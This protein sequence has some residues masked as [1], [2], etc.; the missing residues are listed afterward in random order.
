MVD[1]MFK[2]LQKI[3]VYIVIFACACIIGFVFSR[4]VFSAETLSLENFGT[5]STTGTFTSVPK[6]LLGFTRFRGMIVTDG[7]SAPSANIGQSLVDGLTWQGTDT[8]AFSLSG[9]LWQGKIDSDIYGKYGRLVVG[10]M[11]NATI[12][13]VNWYASGETAVSTIVTTPVSGTISSSVTTSSVGTNSAVIIGTT[14]AF[15]IG[16]NTS[17]GYLLLTNE[18]SNNDCYIAFG[19]TVSTSTGILIS[20]SGGSWESNFVGHIYT[21]AVAGATITGT[22]TVKVMEH[23]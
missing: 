22:T 15:I 23:N 19:S 4:I 6:N 13:R 5:A 8:V 9:S 1:N 10:D 12:L 20:K 14:S 2:L 17:R 16:T 3:S 7:S 21:G 18:D 11:G